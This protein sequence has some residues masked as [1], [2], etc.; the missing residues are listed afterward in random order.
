MTLC[1]LNILPLLPLSSNARGSG[2]PQ[3]RRYRLPT[4]VAAAAVVVGLQGW[5]ACGKT[6]FERPV[7]VQNS[8]AARIVVVAVV[9]SASPCMQLS[10]SSELGAAGWWSLRRGENISSHAKN[11]QRKTTPS[12]TVRVRVVVVQDLQQ[13]YTMCLIQV[14]LRSP[15]IKTPLTMTWETHAP[16]CALNN[17]DNGDGFCDGDLLPLP[18][19]A[20]WGTWPHEAVHA[21]TTTRPRRGYRHCH[22]MRACTRT[23]VA[24]VS[25][26]P[27]RNSDDDDDMG[28]DT[29]HRYRPRVHPDDTGC[30]GRGLRTCPCP[31]TLGDHSE[32]A[33]TA[34]PP[35]DEGS[36]DNL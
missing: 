36:D 6:G 16:P 15:D 2:Q 29:P 27:A 34:T 32:G 28:C 30:N 25:G 20:K 21:P 9:G 22:A 1:Y 26:P 17:N 19:T 5:G 3:Q 18:R 31:A 35:N 23:T 24:A 7:L 13:D 12:A 11:K 33:E 14:I 4:F 10:S 8:I